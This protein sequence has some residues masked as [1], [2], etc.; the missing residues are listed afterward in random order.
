MDYR[1]F[2]ASKHV[3]ATDHGFTVDAADIHPALYPWQSD[4]VRWALV[5]GRAALFE[6][7]GLGKTIQQLEWLA[8]LRV[9]AAAR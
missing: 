8:T 6:E 2:L 4:I 1:E 3:R 7:C 5:K 9:I